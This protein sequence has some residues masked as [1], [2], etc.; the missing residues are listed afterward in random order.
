MKWR[1]KRPTP[2]RQA[3][4][5]QERMPIHS[6][7]DR[8]EAYAS[9][10]RPRRVPHQTERKV[11]HRDRLFL[12][13]LSVASSGPS[14]PLEGCNRQIST[15]HS[16]KDRGLSRTPRAK[17]SPRATTA[18][19]DRS[20]RTTPGFLPS[21]S[22]LS[23]VLWGPTT[24]SAQGSPAPSPSPSDSNVVPGFLPSLLDAHCSAFCRRGEYGSLP[25]S[26]PS[27]SSL[28]RRPSGMISHP[29]PPAR[30]GRG[31]LRFLLR[32]RLRRPHKFESVV[33]VPEASMPRVAASA[34]LETEIPSAV[35]SVVWVSRLDC[36][37]WEE[38]DST[39][40]V[41]PTPTVQAADTARRVE[42]SKPCPPTRPWWR[43]RD[44]PPGA[45]L[46][47]MANAYGSLVRSPVLL[48]PL[49]SRMVGGSGR[50]GS[51]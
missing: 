27:P 9:S 25:P 42:K 15:T 46:D 2:R 40:R 51:S 24:R 23:S 49:N 12:P 44:A 38:G 18:A 32:L 20:R 19:V 43:R 14:L 13:F 22:M 41:V 29:H 50:K 8:A 28:A 34:V 33:A 10:S 5:R 48:D 11:A 1:G 45:G 4:R 26:A 36:R 21:S 35:G 37:R 17:L 6:S 30:L 31:E 16:A 3:D 7:A 47:S 39:R